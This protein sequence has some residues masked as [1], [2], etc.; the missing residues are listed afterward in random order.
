M[1]VPVASV[2]SA[3]GGWNAVFICAAV[4]SIAAALS[5]K[6]VLAPMRKRWISNA[7]VAY[8][9]SRFDALPAAS[10]ASSSGR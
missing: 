4:I 6:F 10:P 7:A 9:N 3:V 1:L 8:E 2:L 5:A